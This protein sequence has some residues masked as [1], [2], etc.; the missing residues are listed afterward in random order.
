[1]RGKA[2]DENL[3]PLISLS[4]HPVPRGGLTRQ[5]VPAFSSWF[6]TPAPLADESLC[7][8]H[9]CLP[10]IPRTRESEKW[11]TDYHIVLD[12]WTFV[13]SRARSGSAAPPN[14]R[15]PQ[16]DSNSW[17]GQLHVVVSERSKCWRAA[18]GDPEKHTGS[19]QR[20]PENM[21]AL[22]G[23][24][25]WKASSSETYDR[26]LADPRV[27]PPLGKCRLHTVSTSER[28]DVKLPGRHQR[29]VVFWGWLVNEGAA[30][31]VPLTAAA[32]SVHNDS[33][34]NFNKWK[35]VNGASAGIVQISGKQF[36]VC[37]IGEIKDPIVST[38]AFVSVC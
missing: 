7:T 30:G 27:T 38:K 1:M 12:I 37:F 36:E 22:E 6:L 18:W 14:P 33:G 34:C 11:G 19:P 15:E 26:I 3:F 25:K 4:D 2:H 35:K 13:C 23:D 24:S 32:S 5:R 20:L 16:Q 8:L 10:L 17:S 28:E 9:L 31:S 21:K 29:R